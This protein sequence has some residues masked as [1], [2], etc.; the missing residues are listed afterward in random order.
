MKKSLPHKTLSGIIRLP[1]GGSDRPHHM[2]MAL[3]ASVATG[4]YLWS[5][6]WGWW[7][8]LASGVVILAHE[9]WATADRDIEEKRVDRDGRG[10]WWGHWY[11]L[12]YGKLVG[13][14]AVWSHGL[15]LGTLCRCV[16]GWWFVLLPLAHYAP[17]LGL[18]WLAC[19]LW[20][21]IWHLV[22]DI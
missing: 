5:E 11:W 21:D 20:C 16:Y 22:L 19:C 6:G 12:R 15:V 13:H 10:T 3:A 18:W 7:F 9:Y 8:S 14:R 4:L 2:R 1:F 17:E